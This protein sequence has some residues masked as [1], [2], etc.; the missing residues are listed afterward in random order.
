MFSKTTYNIINIYHELIYSD[1]LSI[2]NLIHYIRIELR[3]SVVRL[4]TAAEPLISRESQMSEFQGSS[5]SNKE[6][7]IKINMYSIVIFTVV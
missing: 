3:D 6:T 4:M 1:L 2:Y 5:S 7:I